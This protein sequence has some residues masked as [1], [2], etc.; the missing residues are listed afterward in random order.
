MNV[1]RAVPFQAHLPSNFWGECV[2]TAAYLIN[3][4][5]TKIPHG[6]TPYEMLFKATPSYAHIKDFTCL[7]YAHNL[8]RQKDKFGSRNRKCIFIGYP[9]G[10]I[11]RRVYDVE[12]ADMLNSREVTFV[13]E[14]FPFAEQVGHRGAIFLAPYF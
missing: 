2:L 10:K 5:P 3:R 1:A 12:S 9:H 6:K 14:I 13:E 7:C 8:Q 4:T 11:R